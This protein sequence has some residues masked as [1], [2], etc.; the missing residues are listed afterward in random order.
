[1]CHV[2]ELNKDISIRFWDISICESTFRTCN[3]DIF[4]MNMNI[5][6]HISKWI[7][8][9]NE[10]C[11]QILKDNRHLSSTKRCLRN[12]LQV[13][14]LSNRFISLEIMTQQMIK[15]PHFWYKATCRELVKRETL[16]DYCPE[17]TSTLSKPNSLNSMK[18]PTY[19]L[20]AWTDVQIVNLL[21]SR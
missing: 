20:V 12:G 19:S 8:N 21:L 13:L 1:M 3:D 18:C 2:I 7:F 10:N 4:R 9:D 15:L 16:F 14:N 6:I 17:S 11:V 5:S